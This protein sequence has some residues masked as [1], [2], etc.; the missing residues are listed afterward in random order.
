MPWAPPR[1]CPRCGALHAGGACPQRG[2][3]PYDRRAWRRHSQA[4]RAR[5][6]YCGMRADGAFHPDDSICT[7]RGLQILAD[8]VDHIVAIVDGG[9]LLE[10]ANLQ[11]LCGGCHRRKTIADQAG[12]NARG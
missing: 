3:V 12:L 1:A 6:P 11:S 7:R 5:Y 2:P 9:A 10:D 4:F 8:Q